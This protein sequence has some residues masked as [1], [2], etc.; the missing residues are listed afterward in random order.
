MHAVWFGYM[1]EFFFKKTL[2]IHIQLVH[3]VSIVCINTICMQ[4]DR[5][6]N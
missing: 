5:G 2:K 6:N 1:P 4:T 3:N